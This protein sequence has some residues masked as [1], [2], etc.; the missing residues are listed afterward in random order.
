M[1]STRTKAATHRA[2]SRAVF[3]HHCG[4]APIGDELLRRVSGETRTA[5]LPDG[6]TTTGSAHLRELTALPRAAAHH[7]DARLACVATND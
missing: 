2:S 3:A 4:L 6:I 1:A 7:V 5:E